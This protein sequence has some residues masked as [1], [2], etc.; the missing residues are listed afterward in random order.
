M[1][2]LWS[3]MDYNTLMWDSFWATWGRAPEERDHIYW[4]QEWNGLIERGRQIN[5]RSQY[6]PELEP[7]LAYTWDRLIGWQ[8]G[9]ED[10]P[11]Y[12]PFG[13][14]SKEYHEIPPMPGHEDPPSEDPIP[15]PP[16]DP[17]NESKTVIALL[18][19]IRNILRDRL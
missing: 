18:T 11:L 16:S 10:I 5:H 1:G 17:T 2:Q 13:R 12:G 4:T 3:G 15:K 19:E 8:A 6:R 9:G 7:G 14:T